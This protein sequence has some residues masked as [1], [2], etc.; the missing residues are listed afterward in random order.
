MGPSREGYLTGKLDA[1]ARSTRIPTFDRVPALHPDPLRHMPV[2]DLLRRFGGEEERNSCPIALAWLLAQNRS[3]SHP[4]HPQHRSPQ[5][6]LGALTVQLT[7]A[8]L[9]QIETEFST[10]TVHGER[11]DEANMQLVDQTV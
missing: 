6:N 3:S 5:R 9:Q 7:P 1:R 2:V 4:R 10:I 8:E 11:M